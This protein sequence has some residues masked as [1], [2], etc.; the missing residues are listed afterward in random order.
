[1]YS[2]NQFVFA[3]FGSIQA[4]KMTRVAK[5]WKQLG[6]MKIKLWSITCANVQFRLQGQVVKLENRYLTLS[7]K[8]I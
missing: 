8:E 5:F 2:E 6:T 7:W 1:M 3:P 4:A